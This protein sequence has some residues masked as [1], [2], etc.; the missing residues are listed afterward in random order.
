MD[1]KEF[2][3]DCIEKQKFPK[4]DREKQIILKTIMQKFDENKT[5]SEQEV[6]KVI[7]KFYDEFTLIRRELINFGYMQRNPYE[8]KYWVI[9]KELS[10]DELD[11]VG[12]LQD[13]L[14]GEQNNLHLS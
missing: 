5:H 13:S 1:E 11:K 4:D 10:D 8:N 9:K 7:K 12:K 3:E 2:F 6:D 14:N